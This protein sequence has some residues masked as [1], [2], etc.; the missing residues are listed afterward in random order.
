[1]RAKY[2]K[3]FLTNCLVCNKEF[4]TCVS[5]VKMGR[6]K[7]CSKKCWY[8]AVGFKK[9]QIAWN[10]GKGEFLS[11]EMREKVNKALKNS[12]PYWLGKKR[13]EAYKWLNE[14]A[15]KKGITA[16]NWKGGKPKCLDCGKIIKYT[17]KRCKVCHLGTKRMT[18]LEIKLQN[19]IKK[20]NLPYKFVGNG[21]FWIENINPDFI[22]INGEKKAVEV[23]WKTHKENFRRGGEEG[24]KKERL[25][26]CNKYGW[27]MYFIE[28]NDFNKVNRLNLV[29]LLGG[30]FH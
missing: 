25:N 28:V 30:G 15:K 10:K 1:M 19:I 21:K 13:P 26:I 6:G 27:K 2:Q 29:N 14:G 9:G 8:E 17:S 23:Y 4:K 11:P 3:G 24:W 22:N 16:P 7:Y 5:R 12:T 20:Y 18:T